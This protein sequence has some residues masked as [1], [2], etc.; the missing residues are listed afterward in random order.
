MDCWMNEKLK[1]GEFVEIF[2]G[3]KPEI[4]PVCQRNTKFLPHIYMLCVFFKDT[5][6]NVKL[7]VID[8]EIL[9]LI[10][11]CQSEIKK[12]IKMI[13]LWQIF[14]RKKKKFQKEFKM[15]KKYVFLL[16]VVVVPSNFCFGVFQKEI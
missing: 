10:E 5:K 3:S 7:D 11:Q 4:S 14:A 1:K 16:V 12:D 8:I 15:L 6:K 2:S 9:Q 13:K